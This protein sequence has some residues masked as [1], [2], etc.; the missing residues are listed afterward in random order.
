METPYSRRGQEKVLKSLTY[1]SQIIDLDDTDDD[2]TTNDG[3][4]LKKNQYPSLSSPLLCNPRAKGL[5]LA[6][7]L[8]VAKASASHL[9]RL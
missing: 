8:D 3:D 5:W 4:V 1:V 7:A 6:L 9:G 2:Y